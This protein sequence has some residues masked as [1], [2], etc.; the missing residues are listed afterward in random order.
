MENYTIIGFNTKELTLFKCVQGPNMSIKALQDLLS[1]D[2]AAR[3]P[4]IIYTVVLT[5]DLWW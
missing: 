3:F 1:S 2:Q 5:S 4:H